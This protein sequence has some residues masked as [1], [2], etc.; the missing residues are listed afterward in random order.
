MN[1]LITAFCLAIISGV[2]VFAQTGEEYNRNEFFVGYSNQQ[3]DRGEHTT[4]N[5]FEGSY[6]EI[7]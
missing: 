4:F 1:K 3:V 7:I 6:T 2:C 5:G